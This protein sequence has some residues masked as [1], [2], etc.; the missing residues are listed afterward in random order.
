MSRFRGLLL[1]S[2]ARYRLICPDLISIFE[3]LIRFTDFNDS[4]ITFPPQRIIIVFDPSIVINEVM[5][6]KILDNGEI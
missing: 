2:R 5:T 4:F 6:P 1:I 3:I